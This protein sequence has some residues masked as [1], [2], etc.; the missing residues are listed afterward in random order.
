MVSMLY[1]APVT[2]PGNKQLKYTVCSETSLSTITF[3][4]IKRQ[5]RQ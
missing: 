5:K 1:V 4:I 2:N 3:I